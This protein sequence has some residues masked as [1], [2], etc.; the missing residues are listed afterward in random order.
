MVHWMSQKNTVNLPLFDKKFHHEWLQNECSI[1]SYTIENQLFLR[2]TKLF[3]EM[4][5]Q[6]NNFW[7]ILFSS[8][9]S[10]RVSGNS[11]MSRL[12]ICLL[13]AGDVVGPANE[14]SICFKMSIVSSEKEKKGEIKYVFVTV[15]CFLFSED[16]LQLRVLRQ[17]RFTSQLMA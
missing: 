11:R 17:V 1:V 14:F 12:A 10:S 15:V 5:L 6:A 9:S 16:N 2:L 7:W 13:L 3:R 8:S 4:Q